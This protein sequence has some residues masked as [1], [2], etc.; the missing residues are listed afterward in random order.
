MLLKSDYFMQ[1]S[2]RNLTRRYPEIL[3]TPSSKLSTEEEEE[4]KRTVEN[5]IIKNQYLRANEH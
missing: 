4:K 5:F 1:I 2:L 3:I